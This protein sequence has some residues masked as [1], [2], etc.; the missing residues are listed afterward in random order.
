MRRPTEDNS[1]EKYKV[2]P[3]LKM[4]KNGNGATF[5]DVAA[6]HPI[7][8]TYSNHILEA[9]EFPVAFFKQPETHPFNCHE[10]KLKTVP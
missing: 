1:F 7:S 5:E 4:R 2:Y 8:Y 9:S 6:T 10:V 3:L